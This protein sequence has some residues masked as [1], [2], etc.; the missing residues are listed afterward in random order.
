MWKKM[1]VE[2]KYQMLKGVKIN[3]KVQKRDQKQAL[4]NS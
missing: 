3:F 4:E 2:L 1:V